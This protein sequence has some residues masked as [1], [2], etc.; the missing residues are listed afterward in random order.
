[1]VQVADFSHE[2]CGGTHVDNTAEIRI[3]RIISESSVA[4]GVR[5]IEALTGSEALKAYE[6]ERATVAAIGQRLKADPHQVVD[7]LETLLED[8]AWLQKEVAKAS[9]GQ[10]ANQIQQ[11]AAGIQELPGGK[12]IIARVDGF[13]ME[14]MQEAVDKLRDAMGSGVAVLGAVTEDKVAFVAGVTKDLTAKVQAGALVK[15][16]A[17]ETGGSGGGRPEMARAG[18][19]DAAKVDQALAVGESKIKEL[20]G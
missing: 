12:Y 5:R 11:L 16:V 10:A 9:Q 20:L 4:T 17:A 8:H 7:K 15:I 6:Q 14:L 1:M 18:G 13:T 2:L 3:F 19:K